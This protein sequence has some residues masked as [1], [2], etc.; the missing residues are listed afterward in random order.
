M[1]D[2]LY[3][4]VVWFLAGFVNGVTSFGGN[5]FAVPLMALVMDAKTA[6]IL[7]CFV[8]T[9]ITLTI[10]VF[11]HRELPKLEFTEVRGVEGIKEASYQVTD[12][13]TVKV[14]VANGLENASRLLEKIKKGEANYH[15][16]EIMACPGGCVNGGGQPTLSDSVRNST[17]LKETR[18]KALYMSDSHNEQRRYSDSAV[19]KILDLV[20]NSTAKKAKPEKFITKFAKYYTPAVC[21]AALVV[22]AI[23]PTIICAVNGLFAWPTYSEWIS[24]ALS[25]LVISCPCALVISV[26]LSYFGGIGRA[27]KFG[28]LV[29]GSTCLD[30][31]AACTVAAFDK[32]G[33]ITEGSF[34]VI[35]SDSDSAL[36]LAAAAEKFGFDL[37][38]TGMPSLFYLRIAD[39]PTLALHQEWVVE[40]VKRG[41]FFTN[42]HNHFLNASLTDADIAETA[43]V[44]EEAFEVVRK[45]H[46]MEE[47]YD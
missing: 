36:Q 47:Q 6:I 11:Y 30:E 16:I 45:R 8:G 37:R 2:F 44:A 46:P 28:I 32:T 29:K 35:S 34:K 42:H 15:F 5:L 18:A 13:L 27:A 33:T 1:F 41:I 26:P 38:V 31:L 39:D 40:C 12:D 9:A 17:E 24:K 21:A 4:N 19:A 3:V 22:A 7:G 10:A 14:A 43:A 25:F 20:E 23:V